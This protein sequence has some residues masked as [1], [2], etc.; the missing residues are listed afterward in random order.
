M[1]C[2]PCRG[3]CSTTRALGRG[4]EFVTRKISAGVARIKLGLADE[5]RMGNL[6][7]RR[8]WGFAGDYVRAMWMMLQPDQPDDYVVATGKDYAVRDFCEHTFSH[9]D[10][11]Y[12]KY[13]KK[14]PR[15]FRPAEVDQLIGDYSKATGNLGWSPEVGF[16]E[17]VTMMVDADMARLQR[18]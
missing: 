7:S 17:L 12:T 10:L 16:E 4:L 13:V 3:Y 1:T 8:D 5:L 11:D 15:F 6:D 18:S 2:M 9:L 14:D